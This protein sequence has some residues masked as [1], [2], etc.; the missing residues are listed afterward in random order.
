MRSKNGSRFLRRRIHALSPEREPSR[1]AAASPA[2]RRGKFR[3]SHSPRDCCGRGPS[4]LRWKRA[5]APFLRSGILA[6]LGLMLGGLIVHAAAALRIEPLGD[7]I[8][9][10]QGAAGGYRLPLYQLLTNAGY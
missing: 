3:T 2:G 9:Y 10:G 7:S 5:N 8:T 4:A 1:L 6:C